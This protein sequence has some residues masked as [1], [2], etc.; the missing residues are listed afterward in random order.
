VGLG[1]GYLVL[2]T[3]QLARVSTRVAMSMEGKEGKGRRGREGGKTHISGEHT[4]LD[5]KAV[6][7]HHHCQLE[8]WERMTRGLLGMRGEIHQK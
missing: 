4:K 8:Q 1:D 6:P 7:V 3:C 2:G 5:A